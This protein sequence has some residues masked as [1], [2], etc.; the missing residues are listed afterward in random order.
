MV[1]V[2]K[3]ADDLAA[4]NVSEL[5]HLKKYLKEKYGLEETVAVAAAPAVAE[6]AKVE[7]QTEFRVLLTGVSDVTSEK[8]GAVKI[9]NRMLNVGL[10]PAMDLIKEPPVILNERASKIEA[11]AIKA[12]FNA[13]NATIELK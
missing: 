13:L 5:Q 3:L 11:E 9:V 4:L 1:K 8:L 10:K 7:E 6:V 12:E 2:E